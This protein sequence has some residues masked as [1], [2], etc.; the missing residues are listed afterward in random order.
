VIRT[1]GGAADW[2]RSE[3]DEGA[4]AARERTLKGVERMALSGA[5]LAGVPAAPGYALVKRSVQGATAGPDRER[6]VEVV[7][8]AI[9][10][11]MIEAALPAASALL[12]MGTDPLAERAGTVRRMLYRRG[13][14]GELTDDAFAAS[15]RALPAQERRERA[16]ARREWRAQVDRV[17]S[18]SVRGAAQRRRDTQ[19]AAVR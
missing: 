17:V 11:G 3:T 15:L 13:P 5:S 7:V 8:K 4:Q 9:N 6:S 19:V 2:I 18:R 10:S 16:T 14:G 1:S 12:A